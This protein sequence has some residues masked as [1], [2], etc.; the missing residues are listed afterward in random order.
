MQEEFGCDCKVFEELARGSF[1]H[2]KNPFSLT[3]FRISLSNDGIE[4]PFKLTEHTQTK[5]EDIDK[6]PQLSFVDSD[7]NIFED[8]KK[9]LGLGEK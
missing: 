2:G 5:W 9:S 8:I 1:M 7:L 3:A 6:I 4:K